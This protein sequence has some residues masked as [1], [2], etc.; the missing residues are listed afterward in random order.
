MKRLSGI[1]AAA[2]MFFGGTG[3]AGAQSAETIGKIENYLNSLNSLE[4]QFVQVSSNG[5]TAEGSLF[6]QKPNRIR[7]EYADPVSVLIVGNGDYIV[8]HDKELD[9]TTHI[10]YDDIPATLILANDIKIDNKNIKISDF[11]QDKGTTSITL[12]YVQKGDI[13]PITL[14]FNN[15]PF[16]LKQWKV[17]DPQRIEVAVSLYNAQT[18]TPLDASLF[19]FKAPKKKTLNYKKK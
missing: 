17:I 13:G 3:A 15:S 19:K 7:M 8:Y 14:I 16:E 10:D 9:Q 2:F 1:L 5:G 4:A 11:Y 18:D 6:I 12:D